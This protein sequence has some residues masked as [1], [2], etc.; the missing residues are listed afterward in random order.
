MQK[1]KNGLSSILFAFGCC[2]G[3]SWLRMSRIVLLAKW[4]FR[5][6]C[7]LREMVPHSLFIIP[8]WHQLMIAVDKGRSITKLF[9]TWNYYNLPISVPQF[10]IGINHSTSRL[11]LAALVDKVLWYSKAIYV[12]SISRWFCRRRLYGPHFFRL[13]VFT[14][15]HM[16][17]SSWK[18]GRY[19]LFIGIDKNKYH[20]YPFST[21]SITH[22]AVD[23]GIP[24]LRRYYP[25]SGLA[26]SAL[27]TAVLDMEGSILTARILL[28]RWFPL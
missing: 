13:I 20:W 18:C 22:G 14:V 9:S 8:Y 15:V 19:L 3:K 27:C 1:M 21:T 25:I 10:T 5:P 7:N 17:T 11:H 28:E 12:R 6:V 23:S 16:E 2:P 4:R 24:E 26:M